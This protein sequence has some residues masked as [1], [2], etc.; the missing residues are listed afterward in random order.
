MHAIYR[1]EHEEREGEREGESEKASEQESARARSDYDS[2][3]LSIEGVTVD[4]V[5][6]IVCGKHLASWQYHTSSVN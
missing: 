5:G 3:D 2:M 1:K 6:H 4:K